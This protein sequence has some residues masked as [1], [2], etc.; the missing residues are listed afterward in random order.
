MAETSG[1]NP[2]V[3]R[4]L[5]RGND[6]R[7]GGAE[8]LWRRRRPKTMGGLERAG[9]SPRMALFTWQAAMRQVDVRD[10]LASVRVPTLVLH[11]KDDAIPV[12]CGRE[13]AAKIPGGTTRRTRCESPWKSWRLLTLETRMESCRRNSRQG[14]RR[15]VGTARRRRQPRCGWCGRC[16]PSWAPIT[17]R[18]SGSPASSG[19][20]SSRCGPGCARPT[21]TTGMRPGCR[22]RSRSGSRSSSRRSENCKRA[23]EILKR[24]ASFFGAELDRQH[25]K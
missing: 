17:G 11:R 2:L 22:P 15:R 21:S 13:L 7:L 24:A 16:G 10:I 20:A 9:M 8:S 12:E 19:T 6:D 5:G 25:K 1:P 18:C 23:N 14:S 4:P 3:D